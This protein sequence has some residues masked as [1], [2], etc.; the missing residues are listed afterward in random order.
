VQMVM[1]TNAKSVIGFGEDNNDVLHEENR[2]KSGNCFDQDKCDPNANVKDDSKL[3]KEELELQLRADEQEN[4]RI[5]KYKIGKTAFLIVC[6]IINGLLLAIR[7]P[8]LPDLRERVDVPYDEFSPALTSRHIGWIIG[9]L[10]G[11]FCFDRFQKGWDLQLAIGFLV[12]AVAVG[13]KPL[14]RTV[15]TMAL[16]FFGEGLA[17]GIHGL[18]GNAMC[19]ALW[20]HKAPPLILAMS[21]GFRGGQF[22]AP[23]LA[24]PFLGLRNATTATIGDIN[25]T[26]GNYSTSVRQFSS[27]IEI[28]HLIVGVVGAVC[29]I[30]FLIFFICPKPEKLVLSNRPK[31]SKPLEFL[32]PASCTGGSM[33]AGILFTFTFFLY[34]VLMLV[35]GTSFATYQAPV[36][37]DTLGLTKPDSALMSTLQ[38]GC[39][40]ASML[41]FTPITRCA[42]I[43]ALVYIVHH[44]VLAI[45]IY[46]LIYGIESVQAFA[47]SSCVYDVF[48]AP[49]FGIGLSWAQLY[50]NTTGAAIMCFNIGVG[51]GG[52]LS[53]TIGGSL[54]TNTGAKG[55][56]W[57]NLI[58]S[59]VFCV[60]VYT[61]TVI[62]KC[63]G[64]K[65][66]RLRKAE[67]KFKSEDSRT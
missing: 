24:Y 25:A 10:I 4:A 17:H 7:F 41:I 23:I 66:E 9:C 27:D 57:M 42:P 18:V 58:C 67:E 37:Q 31:S 44:G 15:F 2:E 12:Q 21:F 29:A 13:V 47:V 48:S 19:L 3:E 14:S 56:L 52:I 1:S 34:Y 35:T 11:G 30:G 64:T 22:L 55:L 54:L 16:C 40:L 43:V 51:V 6:W 53:E 33:G 20:G 28:P 62:M 50:M 32:S 38:K 26:N 45:N 36:T 46:A 8:T 65:E 39:G 5:L 49:Y 63:Y 60:L 59:I 61:T